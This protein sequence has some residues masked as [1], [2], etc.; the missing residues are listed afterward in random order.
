[1][2]SLLVAPNSASLYFSPHRNSKTLDAG[3]SLPQTAILRTPNDISRALSK[4][5]P[6]STP[7]FCASISLCAKTNVKGLTAAIPDGRQSGASPRALDTVLTEADLRGPRILV[8]VL[9]VKRLEKRRELLCVKRNA[10]P[11]EEVRIPLIKITT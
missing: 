6:A 10:S 11:T 8:E 2:K 1:M 5:E 7:K 3:Q 4:S 9:R